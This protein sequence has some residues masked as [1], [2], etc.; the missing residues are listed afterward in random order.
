M[1]HLDVLFVDDEG[2]VLEGLRR[3]LAFERR[4]RLHF[5]L[6]GADALA[7]L[8][9][10]PIDVVVTDMRMPGMDGAAL[11][12]EVAERFPDVVR[13]I[14]SGHAD[15]D[16]ALRAMT[17]AHQY[18]S[19]PCDRATLVRVVEHALELRTRLTN[20]RM[21]EVLGRVGTLPPVPQ[22]YAQIL[23]I[24]NTPDCSLEQIQDV[25][26]RDPLI[27]GK[28]LQL[29]NSSFFGRS[30]TMTNLAAA[31]G[32]LGTK[33]VRNLVLTAE[34]SRDLG[35][36]PSDVELTLEALQDHSLVVAEIASQLEPGAPWAEDAYLA[37][38][39]HD[40]GLLVLATRLPDDYR[41]IEAL[42]RASGEPRIEVERRVLGCHHGELGAYLFSL[43]GLP[44]P[45]VDAV[46]AHADLEIA[47]HEPLNAKLAVALAEE[48]VDAVQSLAD[49]K[50][51]PARF[52]RDPRWSTWLSRAHAT[53]AKRAA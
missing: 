31:V 33:M 50:D 4:W 28:V 49:A 8:E 13:V 9:S 52:A 42:C 14:L 2:R 45:I 39:L 40:T 26:R 48:L 25:V 3:M 43:W 34:L 16:T 5:A 1:S 24:L 37:G 12:S 53:L 6:S 27:A 41:R 23:R 7:V 30:G 36:L 20:T 47:P 18:L 15:S 44:T 17:A 35:E 51:P 11:L 21:R 32:M 19:K 10:R 46:A 22:T 29:A 38:L